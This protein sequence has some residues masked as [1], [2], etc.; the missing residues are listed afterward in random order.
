LIREYLHTKPFWPFDFPKNFTKNY[1]NLM[2][3]LCE[4]IHIESQAIFLSVLDDALRNSQFFQCINNK[5]IEFSN[6]E[7]NPSNDPSPINGNQTLHGRS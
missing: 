5:V 3:T 4:K 1:V 2:I 6:Y 7:N